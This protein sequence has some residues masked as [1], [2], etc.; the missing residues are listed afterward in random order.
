[1]Q[2]NNDHMLK[3]LT[4]LMVACLLFTVAVAQQNSKAIAPFKIQLVNK[5]YYTYKELKK[6]TPSLLVYFSPTCEHCNTFVKELLKH[7][8]VIASKQ[9]VLIT[10]LPVEELKPFVATFGLDKYAN[11]HT[12]TEGYTFIVRKY[13][14]VER[15]PFVAVYDKQLQLKKVLPYSE[16]AAKTVSEVLRLW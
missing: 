12:G 1:M 14:N 3:K 4:G 15:F 13:Y 16:D 6:N 2:L 5:N 7:K 8:D 11:I 10:Y 9:I